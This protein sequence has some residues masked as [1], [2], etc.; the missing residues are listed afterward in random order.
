MSKQKMS[1]K[2]RGELRTLEVDRKVREAIECI[3]NELNGNDGVYPRNGGALSCNE[4][5]RRAGIGITTLYS[6]KLLTLRSYVNSWLNT[7]RKISPVER[8]GFRKSHA[9]RAKMWKQKFQALAASHQKTELDL[10]AIQSELEELKLENEK[11]SAR[12]KKLS[13][14]GKLKLVH[15]GSSKS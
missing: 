12:I 15:G 5:A 11:L 13:E 1:T 14:N 3:T 4:V 10:L 7:V 6:S 2:A 9:I 8:L